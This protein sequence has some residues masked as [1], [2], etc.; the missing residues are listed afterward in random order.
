[1]KISGIC[2]CGKEQDEVKFFSGK[3]TA[4]TGTESPFHS[5]K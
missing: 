3:Q 5:L 4:S 2:I 1:M